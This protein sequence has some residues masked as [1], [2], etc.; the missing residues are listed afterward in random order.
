MDP[1]CTLRRPRSIWRWD[2]LSPATELPPLRPANGEQHE[3]P[4]D[5]GE[6][7]E[8]HPP[9]LRERADFPFAH[10]GQIERTVS[11]EAG[12][13]RGYQALLRA[14]GLLTVMPFLPFFRMAFVVSRE[15]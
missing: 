15:P 11:P 1:L 6:D 9:K 7:Q 4:K 3:R 5:V 12:G 10:P 13:G 8:H 14:K 2:I